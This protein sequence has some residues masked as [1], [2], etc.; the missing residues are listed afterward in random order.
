MTY[1]DSSAVVPLYVPE[2]FSAAARAAARDA[3]QVP[4]T[5]LH[6]LE[7][8]SAFELLVGRRAISRDECRAILRQLDDDIQSQR[9]T[10]TALDLERVLADASDVSRRFTAR[11]LTRSLDLLHVAAAHLALCGTFVSADDRQLAAARA[12]GLAALDIK[13]PPRRRRLNS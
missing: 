9:L 12:S 1:F 13:R 11:F 4:F 5:A 7:V 6:R 2:R 3:G 8:L 10:P